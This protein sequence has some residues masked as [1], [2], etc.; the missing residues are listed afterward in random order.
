M[1]TRPIRWGV[2]GCGDVVARK[3]AGGLLATPGQRIVAAM[4]RDEAALRAFG[5]RFD[6]P[7][8]TTS[9]DALLSRE[10]VDL[11]Y[12][13]TP[14]D[15]HVH[16]AQRA[17]AAGKGVLVEKPCGRC[18]AETV[19][20]DAACAAAGVPLFASYYRRHLPKFRH[21][22]AL[23]D[24]GVIG[25]VVAASYRLRERGAAGGWRQSPQRAGG[26]SF[27]DLA[28]H[29]L[30]ILDLLLGPLDCVAG[31]ARN[32]RGGG[33]TEDLVLLQFRGRAA[34]GAVVPGHAS[35]CFAS[36]EKVDELLIEGQRGRIRCEAMKFSGDVFV[37]TDR[38]LAD[39]GKGSPLTRARKLLRNRFRGVRR[40]VA[41]FPRPPESHAALFA[42]IGAAMADG[43]GARRE[44]FAPALR[45]ARLLDGALAGYYGGREIG[46]WEHPER[47]ASLR[48]RARAQAAAPRPRDYAADVTDAVRARFVADGFAGPFDTDIEGLASAFVP[49]KE[50][51]DLHLVDAQ[52][53]AIAT[54]A[55]VVDRVA[56][57]VGTPALSI[58][59]S[60]LHNK[61]AETAKRAPK[62]AVVPWHQDA[63]VDNG[64]HDAAGNAIET[65]TVW[66]ALD[67]V[68]P[69]AGPVRVLPGTHRRLY[70][71]YN[72]NFDARL[73]ECGLITADDVARA[74]PLTMRRGQFCVFHSWLLHASAP[75]DSL[76]RRAGL[77]VRFVRDADRVPGEYTYV[78]VSPWPS[79]RVA[80]A[81][82][83]DPLLVVDAPAAAHWHAREAAA[84]VH[85]VAGAAVVKA[86]VHADAPA[87]A[88]HA[89]VA[90]QGT[91]AMQ[92]AMPV[93]M[94]A[95]V[96]AGMEPRTVVPGTGAAAESGNAKAVAGTDTGA[97]H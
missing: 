68:G 96:V 32:L 6:V 5:E 43:S 40:D 11:V 2:I 31:D 91:A 77:N 10:D 22:R 25:P 50:R 26:G 83:A 76:G 30:D 8:V 55:S 60:R 72:E 42:A 46:F 73:V 64:G 36:T 24:T 70:G 27:Q 66:L 19:A 89:G 57:L 17:A 49:E 92:T 41:T 28:G 14:P 69:G 59:K 56:A 67:D 54:H 45:T 20:I 13:A 16:Y 47:F 58:F 85:A 37:E 38:T 88:V 61:V 74:V 84:D 15:L 48:A 33:I 21:V 97:R 9:A 95:P 79:A 18:G 81:A 65:W 90:A 86:P 23:L 94:H 71:N 44:H 4:R 63:G 82:V 78:E 80:S 93:A 1:N 34:D 12:I 87:I 29:V 51:K 53:F 35:F 62:H 75:N 52:F 7:F 3:A 39:T